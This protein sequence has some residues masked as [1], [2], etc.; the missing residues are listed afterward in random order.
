[1][2]EINTSGGPHEVVVDGDRAFEIDYVL[3][4]PVRDDIYDYLTSSLD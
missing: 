1:M 2:G 3:E 4:T